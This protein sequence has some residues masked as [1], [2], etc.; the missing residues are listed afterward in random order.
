[1]DQPELMP[2]TVG[3]ES[4]RIERPFSLVTTRC[5]EL[6]KNVTS[7]QS[8]AVYH[9]RKVTGAAAPTVY[10]RQRRRQSR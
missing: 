3:K 5:I 8:A 1:M 7:I 6:A 2:N 4:G 10:H 9:R